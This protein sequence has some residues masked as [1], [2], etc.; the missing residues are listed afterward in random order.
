MNQSAYGPEGMELFGHGGGT[1]GYA[2][3]IGFDKKQRRGVVLLSNQVVIHSSM[4]GWR[5]LQHARLN[6]I[7][8]AKMQPIREMVGTG[9]AL[10]LDKETHFIRIS[11]VYSNSCAAKAGLS[12]DLI[13]QKIE[14]V[15][16]LNKSLAESLALFRANGAAKV[17]LEL[18]D[19]K[20]KETNTVELA[21]GKF[22]MEQ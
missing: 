14:G 4:V 11:K 16:T 6:G 15:S 13:I 12:A 19:P 21:R 18:S 22:L 7:E 5:I 1:G 17:R 10:D 8:P 9:I 2:T 3:F 20:K